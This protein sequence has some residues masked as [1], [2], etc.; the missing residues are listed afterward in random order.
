M[1]GTIKI[2]WNC[3]DEIN[4]RVVHH[5][6][7]GITN[8]I[9]RL[10]KRMDEMQQITKIYCWSCLRYIGKAVGLQID[11]SCKSICGECFEGEETNEVRTKSIEVHIHNSSGGGGGVE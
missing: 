8:N 11:T 4:E 3:E 10:H 2:C 5:C 9:N 6:I 7:K 1:N